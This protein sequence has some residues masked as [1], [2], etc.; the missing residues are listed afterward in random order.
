MSE[1]L[2][3]PK[4]RSPPEHAARW[5]SAAE[6]Q[7]R[8]PGLASPKGKTWSWCAKNGSDLLEADPMMPARP[9]GEG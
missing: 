5:D 8:K 9:W 6:V 1:W 3:P 7:E 4:Q 2:D